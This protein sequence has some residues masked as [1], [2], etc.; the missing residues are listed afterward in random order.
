[1]QSIRDGSRSARSA[2]LPPLS[3]MAMVAAGI[4]NGGVVMRPYVV[5]RILKPDGYDPHE[6]G[7]DEY[8]RG[9]QPA[10]AADLTAMMELA[11]RVG[12]RHGCPDPGHPRRRQDRYGGNRPARRERRLVHRVRS[13]R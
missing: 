12:D 3:Q 10:T 7:P 9:S 8:S 5:D 4:A 13:R 1:M 6:D 11:V 2:F